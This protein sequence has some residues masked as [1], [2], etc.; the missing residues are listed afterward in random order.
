MDTDLFIQKV[1][2][3]RAAQKN[4]FRTRLPG[5]LDLSRG[6]EREVDNMLCEIERNLFEHE[7]NGS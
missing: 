4:Y 3:M 2:E 6:L 7:N 1:R 5:Y